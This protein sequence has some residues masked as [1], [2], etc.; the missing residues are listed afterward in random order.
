MLSKR[1]IIKEAYAELGKASYEFDLNPEDLQAALRKL[2]TMMASWNGMG[3]RIGY[4]GGQGSGDIDVSSELPGWADD[5]IISNLA[6]RLAPGLGKI[7]SP[8]TKAA[9]ASGFNTIMLRVAAPAVR[10]KVGYGGAGSG[11]HSLP[12]S[13]QNIKLA[14]DGELEF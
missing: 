7:P 8:E 6:I 3:V 4:A 10:S 1:E 5:A 2:D 12:Q 14:A 11:G 13:Q 9:A